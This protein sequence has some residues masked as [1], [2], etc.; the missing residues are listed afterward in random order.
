MRQHHPHRRNKANGE[1]RR[2]PEARQRPGQD[3]VRLYGRHAVLAALA[4]PLRN[5]H[6]LYLAADVAPLP[7]LPYGL[8]AETLDKRLAARL[9]PD[10]VPHQG[11][12]VDCAPLQPLWL[13]DVIAAAQP[14]A[15]LLMLDHVTDPQNVGAILRSAAAFGA[16]AIITQDRHSPAESGALAKAASGA[17]EVVPWVR[18]T[19]LARTL[20]QIG[21]AGYWRIGLA[22]EATADLATALTGTRAAC[23]VMGAEGSGLRPN[24]AGHCDTLAHL[25]MSGA[26]ESLNVSVAAAIALYAAQERARP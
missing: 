17:L 26:V 13:E 15:P 4:N 1:Q 6:R 20:E 21:E 8:I 10:H 14:G 12:I 16:A 2:T 5:C 9:L 25:P 11:M 18:V 19:N 23:L 7:N 22:G 24:V 3:V